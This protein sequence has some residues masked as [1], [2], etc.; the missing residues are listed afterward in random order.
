MPLAKLLDFLLFEVLGNCFGSLETLMLCEIW[1]ERP[2][3]R[4]EWIEVTSLE[5]EKW[6]ICEFL[7]PFCLLEKCSSDSG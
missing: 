3:L 6:S 5:K 4:Q 2:R 7:V 1:S